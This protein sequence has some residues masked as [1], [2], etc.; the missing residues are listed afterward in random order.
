MF[1][2]LFLVIALAG[3][4]SASASAQQLDINWAS[5]LFKTPKHD[6]GTVARGAATEHVFYFKNEL[7]TDI[8]VNSVRA[9]C[10]CTTPSII[11]QRVKPGETGGIRAKFNTASFVGQRGAT[12]TIQFGSPTFSEVQV[13]V[14]GYVRRDI[15]FTPGNVDFGVVGEGKGAE[16]VVSLAYAGRNDW[17]ITKVSSTNKYVTAELKETSRGG[18]RVGYNVMVKLAADAPANYLS[19]SSLVFETDDRALKQVPL[20]VTG[21]VQSAIVASPKV[22][23]LSNVKKGST[24]NKSVLLRGQGDFEI[25]EIRNADGLISADLPNGAKRN[26]IV[27]LNINTGGEAKDMDSEVTILATMN[28][29]SYQRIIKVQGKVIE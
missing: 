6:F 9:S 19:N 5:K 23:Y 25:K 4:F 7:T 2:H 22:M 24:I 20:Q 18:G 17:K 3:C 26:H 11:K 27:K 14:D 12:V 13:R 10:N 8:F 1:R 29:K 21:N 15:V 16:K 28:G